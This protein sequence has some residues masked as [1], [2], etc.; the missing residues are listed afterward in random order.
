[1]SLFNSPYE[2][3]FETA[4]RIL[5]AGAGGGFDVFCGLPLYFSLKAQDKDVF[6][7]N[8][9]FTNLQDFDGD[10]ITPTMMRVNPETQGFR[11]LYFPEWYLSQWLAENGEDDP[12]IYSFLRNGVLPLIDNYQKLC[13]M[14]K[15]DMIVLVDGGTD[16]LMRGD[17]DGL[18][19]PGEDL[20][21]I[22]AV[23]AVTVPQKMLMCLGFG[24][25]H[26][27][28]VSNDLTL[29]AIAELSKTQGFLGSASLTMEMSA[30]Q[31]YVE[32]TDYVFA[33]MPHDISIV[34]S[35]IVSAIK[36]LYGDHHATERTKGSSLWINPLMAICWFFDLQSIVKRNLICDHLYTTQDYREI[37][38]VITHFRKQN[39]QKMR[40]RQNIPN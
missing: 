29:A 12:A 20:A 16:S 6:L 32:A 15:I 37:I 36:G 38:H 9:S 25:D 1:M 30:V 4:Q 13:D 11:G 14:L 34:S 21:S 19:T 33:A 18:G 28:G 7:A 27:H 26:Y 31:K 5:I 22:T 17:E 23:S 24:V 10:W 3:R 40:R 35:S 8:F 39:V 2:E